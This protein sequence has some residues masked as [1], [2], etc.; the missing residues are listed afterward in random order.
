MLILDEPWDDGFALI[1]VISPGHL[2][3]SFRHLIWEIC[4]FLEKKANT[5][6]VGGAG[7]M[8]NAGINWCITI[9][10]TIIDH[11]LPVQ[12]PIP[13]QL[14][15]VKFKLKAWCMLKPP[16]IISRSRVIFLTP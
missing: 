13:F 5:E 10:K 12:F 11:N 3:D 2:T 15:Y 9:F 8:G 14:T 1:F 6:G 4:Q 7:G 16:I